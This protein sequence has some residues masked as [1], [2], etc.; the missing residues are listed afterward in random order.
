MMIESVALKNI[1]SYASAD[2][3][4]KS[5]VNFIKGANGTGKTTLIEAVGYALFNVTSTGFSGGIHSYLLREGEREGVV[6]VRFSANGSAY[7]VMRTVSA[8]ASRRKWQISSDGEA[9][10]GLLTDRDKVAFLQDAMGLPPDQK[11]GQAVYRHDRRAAGTVYG[12]V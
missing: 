3:H 12:A 10:E 2:I 4:F 7:E 9:A 6:R 11:I 8:Q 1:K 5:G